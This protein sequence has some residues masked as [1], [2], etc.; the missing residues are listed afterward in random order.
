MSVES[1]PDEGQFK[2]V[3]VGPR[4]YIIPQD[5]EIT[6]IDEIANVEYGKSLP[7]SEGEIPAIGSSGIYDTVGDSLIQQDTIVIGRKG[8]AGEAYFVTGGCWPS[9]T[10]FYLTDFDSDLVDIKF[11]HEYMSYNSLAEEIEQT[12]L[13]S[14][15]R[16]RLETYRVLMPP[17][18]EQRRIADILSIVDEQIQQ[19]DKIIKKT[20]KLKQGLMQDLFT[21]GLNDNKSTKTRL[22][23]KVRKMPQH[24]EV[25][26]LSEISN[27]KRGASPRPIGNDEY[28]GG[29]VGWIRIS[30]ITQTNSKY[31][32][33]PSDRLSEL[34]VSESVLIEPETL[35]LSISAT[36]GKPAILRTKG[37]IHDGIVALRNLRENVDIEYLYYALQDLQPRIQAQNQRAAGHQ[38]NVNSKVVRQ[39]EIPL[40]PL[41]EQKEIAEILGKVDMKL[42]DEE[43]QL[44]ALKSLKR[45]LMQDLLTGKVRTP[46][47]ILD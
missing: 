4:T 34:G 11:L 21:K 8:S 16:N 35:V 23:A 3:R 26:R 47:D 1:L 39:S 10:T 7:E 13:P 15:D 42:E 28:F 44:K 14:L 17:L 43:D 25:V 27:I 24:W 36:I 41:E 40:P 33:E 20:K 9:D 6:Q 37:C 29:D 38:T 5:W 46:Q 2:E 12:T 19:T 31:V 30:D 32:T 22:G 45:A 18:S